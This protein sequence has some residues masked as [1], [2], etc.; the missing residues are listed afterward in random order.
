MANTIAL[1]KKYVPILDELYR[2]SALTSVL[3]AR[4]EYV[5]EAQNANE[6]L[7]PKISMDGLGEYGRNTGFVA[8]DVDFSWET[9]TF[10]QDRGRTFMLDAQ[11]DEE[12][13]NTAIGGVSREFIPNYVA[14]EVDAYRFAVLADKAGTKADADLTKDTVIEAIDVAREAM[15]EAKVNLASV[16]TFVSPSTYTKMKQSHLITRQFIV[17]VGNA[18]INREI[19]VLDGSPVIIVPQDRFY[20]AITLL[21]GETAGQEAGGYEKAVGALDI[22]FLMVDPRACMGIKK[23]AKPRL[24]SPEV[25]QKADAWQYDYRLYHDMFVFDNKVKGVYLHTVASGS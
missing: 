9:H 18:V 11:D 15:L 12:T 8:G 4:P 7:I 14:P 3:D 6:I 2:I 17:N 19:E 22:N 25:N 21:D 24:F 23:T 16:L 13:I 5:K 1:A 10:T 20:S